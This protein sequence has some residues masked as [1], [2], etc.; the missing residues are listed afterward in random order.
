MIEVNLVP[1]GS[2][3]GGS[4]GVGSAGSKG[5]GSAGSRGDGSK[6]VGQRTREVSAAGRGGAASRTHSRQALRF[7]RLRAWRPDGWSVVSGVVALSAI[8]ICVLFLV[9]GRSHRVELDIALAKALKDSTAT[10]ES[11]RAWEGFVAA[12]DSISSLATLI[13]DL[14]A[15][16]Y[17][18]P[19]IL[20][21][22]STALPA[23]IRITRIAALPADDN[24]IRVLLEGQAPDSFTL[25]RFW[26]A[27]EASF[28]IRDVTLVKAEQAPAF[29][30]PD[31]PTPYEFAFEA[32]REEPPAE[33]LDFATPDHPPASQRRA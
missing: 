4:R 21:E 18:W 32:A 9:A 27:M 31:M 10:A 22:I 8:G 2:K 14:D 33:V 1:R 7:L 17:H 3:A 5:V 13:E 29:A 23:G 16:R 11:V 26:N 28:F 30:A 12:R 6:G 25:T 24:R 20:D 15:R 19:H